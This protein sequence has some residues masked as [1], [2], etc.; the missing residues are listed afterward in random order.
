[1]TRL[2]S[3]RLLVTTAIIIGVLG[4]ARN[5]S[6]EKAYGLAASNTLILFD[7]ST[8]GTISRTVPIT[9]LGPADQIV[10]IDYVPG[11]G[12]LYGLGASSRLYVIDPQS[13][14]PQSI[15]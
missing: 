12:R 14:S 1:M 6:A 13:G 8:P 7:T 15:A 5:G 2:L 4:W 9:F 11:E 10:A 3:R